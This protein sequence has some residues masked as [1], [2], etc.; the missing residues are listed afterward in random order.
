[1]PTPL[2]RET[3]MS[4]GDALTDVTRGLKVARKIWPAG[5]YLVGQAAFLHIHIPEGDGDLKPGTHQFITHFDDIRADDW[6]VV[7]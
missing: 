2:P 4:Y 6:T 3:V 5:K 7:R 1:M